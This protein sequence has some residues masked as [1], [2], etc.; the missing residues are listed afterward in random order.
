MEQLL[1]SKRLL[2]HWSSSY[3]SLDQSPIS[4]LLL[5]DLYRCY[6]RWYEISMS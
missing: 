2:K 4:D 6:Q 3:E 1:Q 5:G